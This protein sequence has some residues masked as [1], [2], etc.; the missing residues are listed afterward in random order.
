M[1]DRV[2]S[3]MPYLKL[4][5]RMARPNQILLIAVVFSWGILMALVR[6][7]VWS[8]LSYLFG[9]GAAILISISIHFVNEY[10]DYETD[11]L[12]ERTPYSGGSGALQDT[13]LDRKLAILGAILVLILGFALALL[14]Y[15][16]GVLPLQVLYLLGV[17]TLFGWGY[18]LEPLKFAWRGWGEL[19]N[20]LLG[21]WLLPVYGYTVI[22]HK[23][24]AFVMAA[25]A[26]F[27][28]FAFVNLL[29]THWADREADQSVGKITLV[30]KLSIPRLRILYILMTLSAY[31]WVYWYSQYPPLVQV[32]SFIVVP[33]SVWGIVSFTRRHNPAPSV[34]AMVAFLLVQLI[35]WGYLY[36]SGVNFH[37]I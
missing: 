12:T 26:P 23:A 24:D 25:A 2:K 30:T 34:F 28:M 13:H 7:S 4:Y 1:R 32:S 35:S 19:D 36:V 6:G 16:L 10:A 33:V 5:F 21:G 20:A 17:A 18:S 22:N 3:V 14:G 27:A 29:A 8:S 31:A 11:M 37:S 9:L 15:F